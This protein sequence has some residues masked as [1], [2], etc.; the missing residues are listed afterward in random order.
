MY[1]VSLIHVLPNKT[2]FP[3]RRSS[4]LATER[5]RRWTLPHGQPDTSRDTCAAIGER[6]PRRRA[7]P[8]PPGGWSGLVGASR[9]GDR[10][11]TRLNSSHPSILYAVFCLEKKKVV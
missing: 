7:A 5:A 9:Q 1:F 8:R 6:R 4:D 10:K 2:P 3:S 11:S